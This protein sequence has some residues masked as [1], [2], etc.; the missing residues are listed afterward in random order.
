MTPSGLLKNEY[1]QLRFDRHFLTV[2]TSNFR[3]TPNTSCLRLM[4]VQSGY[5]T[6]KPLVVSKHTQ[7]TLIPNTA[8]VHALV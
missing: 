8:S 3:P 1:F 4:T 5:G 2:S 7:G 6:I